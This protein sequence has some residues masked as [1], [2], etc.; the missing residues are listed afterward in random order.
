MYTQSLDVPDGPAP[1]F[2][3]GQPA[4]DQVPTTLWAQVASRRLRMAS[5]R[6][7]LGCGAMGHQPLREAIAEYLVTSRGVNCSPDQVAIVSGVPLPG[8]PYGWI[9]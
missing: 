2:R 9:P 8:S 7:L 3:I 1:A 4:L 6:L 5:A